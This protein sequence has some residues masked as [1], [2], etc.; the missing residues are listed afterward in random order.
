MR[1]NVNPA[2]RTKAREKVSIDREAMARWAL[3][4]V[5]ND[6]MKPIGDYS[7]STISN[8]RTA[9]RSFQ[10]FIGYEQS[11][12]NVTDA[13]LEGF[14]E[15]LAA[16]GYDEATVALNV[17]CLSAVVRFADSS[18]LSSR[19]VSERKPFA[20]AEIVGTIENLVV[21]EY[22]PVNARITSDE[23]KRQYGMAIARFST[24]L[25]HAAQLADL[26]DLALDGW[27]S[28]M[29]SEG[30]KSKSI[31]NYVNY[32]RAF[33]RWAA[34]RG[35][36]DNSPE[37]KI[38]FGIEPCS[39]IPKPKGK[40]AKPPS[41]RGKYIRRGSV[42]DE[43]SV[44]EMNGPN[45][46]LRF[47]SRYISTRDVSEKYAY[48]IRLYA[49]KI[50]RFAGTANIED[51]FTEDAFNSFSASLQGNP[52]TARSTLADYVVLWNAAGDED[53]V[54]YPRLRRLRRPKC[55]QLIIECYTQAEVG[56]L[57]QAATELRG[58][59]ANG[60]RKGLY[61]EAIIRLGWDTG[62]RRG[63]LMRFKKSDVRADG[64]LRVVQSK[65]RRIVPVKIREST[66]KALDAIQ[67]DQPL[68]WTMDLTYFGRH[69]KRIV[70]ASGVGKG[71][72]K[73]VR[74]SSGTYVDMKQ[75]GAG[76]KHLGHSNPQMFDK[77]YDGHLGDHLLPQPPELIFDL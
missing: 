72:F 39:D 67:Y 31:I 7:P 50:A 51:I 52:F 58:E 14:R 53:L 25:G 5:I 75:P 43:K 27:C 37:L 21:N 61:W 35:M 33:W 38:T 26:C 45:G 17:D 77:H 57:L 40:A 20:D 70:R 28:A 69:F 3:V 46:I 63:D 54:P 29:K 36:V 32:L 74:R 55:P 10:R 11:P 9:C 6:A 41:K 62:L 23:T 4:K 47:A 64:S 30:L 18:L 34:D 22:F 19:G 66:R 65:T 44:H 1:N 59:Y 60:V 49:V 73:W 68:D 12:V 48:R 76:S 15:W 24:F 16:D 56:R 13:K 8:Y 2:K 71:S 42:A